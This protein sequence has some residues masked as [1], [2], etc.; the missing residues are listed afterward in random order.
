[1]TELSNI[2]FFLK[3]GCDPLKLTN[4]K[5]QWPWVQY[6]NSLTNQLCV[7]I[8]FILLPFMLLFKWPRNLNDLTNENQRER[9]AKMQL[10]EIAKY[11]H[12]PLT[13]AAKELQICTSS[14]KAICRRYRIARWP[15]RK[16]FSLYYF[17]IFFW[18]K[19]QKKRWG[20]PLPLD[21][22]LST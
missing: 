22:K 13:E 18:E 20:L 5:A 11:F 19:D 6:L 17:L 12:L 8:K 16:V 4:W 10:E 2:S 1:M 14:L 3:W 15:Q 9:T 7:L 21:S